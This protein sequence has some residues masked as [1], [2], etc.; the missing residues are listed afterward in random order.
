MKTSVIEVRDLVSPLTAHG[1]DRM[2]LQQPGIAY[3]AVN[4]VIGSATMARDADD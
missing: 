2:L 3:T 4:A 1:I